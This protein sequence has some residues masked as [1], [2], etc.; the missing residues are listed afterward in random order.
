MDMDNRGGLTVGEG[1]KATEE[2]WDKCNI[3]TMKNK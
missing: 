1:R 2:N 3:T